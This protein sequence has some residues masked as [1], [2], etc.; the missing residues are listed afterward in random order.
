MMKFDMRLA[1][2]P[3]F[4]REIPKTI[5]Y[6]CAITTRHERKAGEMLII[7]HHERKAGEMPIIAH[8]ERKSGETPISSVFMTN[9]VHNFHMIY[10]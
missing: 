10:Q 5:K 8:Q 6:N 2:V 7:A 3:D 9:K 1:G 4:A